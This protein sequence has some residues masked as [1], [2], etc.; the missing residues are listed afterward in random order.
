MALLLGLEREHALDAELT[1]DGLG[2]TMVGRAALE[3]LLPKLRQ[4]QSSWFVPCFDY[5]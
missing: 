3:I 1:S 4:H 5:N 2:V